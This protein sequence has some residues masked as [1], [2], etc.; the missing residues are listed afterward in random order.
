MIAWNHNLPSSA[1][2]E[3]AA[4]HSFA[5][6]ALVA[7]ATVE[8]TA[9]LLR[10]EVQASP[11]S[12]RALPLLWVAIV[13]ASASASTRASTRASAST[14]SADA[15]YP[16]LNLCRAR[17]RYVFSR[18]DHAGEMFV[19]LGA[20]ILQ[21]VASSVSPS[22]MA[23]ASS[24]ASAAD[25]ATTRSTSC[26]IYNIIRENYIIAKGSSQNLT[27]LYSSRATNPPATC[28]IM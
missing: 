18:T 25:K 22:A 27:R 6:A 28:E 13:S 17:F 24:P 9:G 3:W 26:H 21:S 2:A 4:L 5:G 10:G 12:T 7:S 15:L 8:D 23:L 19:E 20:D 14:S 11:A 16:I 1:S